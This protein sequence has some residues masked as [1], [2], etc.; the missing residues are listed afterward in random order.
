MS[1]E[2]ALT[3]HEQQAALNAM[4]PNI[5]PDVI[6]SVLEERRFDVEAAAEALLNI[7]SGGETSLPEDE[8]SSLQEQLRVLQIA[9]D[10]ALALQLSAADVTDWQ[11]ASLAQ[12]QLGLGAAAGLPASY[13]GVHAHQPHALLLEQ[14]RLQQQQQQQFLGSWLQQGDSTMAASSS[15]AQPPTRPAAEAYAHQDSSLS[16]GISSLGTAVASAGAA[17]LATASSLASSLWSWATEPDVS[18]TPDR[19]LRPMPQRHEPR[20]ADDDGPP[21]AHTG[22]AQPSSSIMESSSV[23]I[24]GTASAGEVR[25][26]ARRT[27]EEDLG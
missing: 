3:G 4:F 26:R 13:P 25:R 24:P 1:S 27:A 9:E 6:A 17:T 11:G 15:A 7:S 22:G 21:E 20:G 23:S 18:S 2:G 10:E 14:A 12:Q 5:S 16:S 19:E 8:A